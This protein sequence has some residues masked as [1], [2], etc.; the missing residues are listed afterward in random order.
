[1][2]HLSNYLVEILL[3][4][5]CLCALYYIRKIGADYKQ[6]LNTNKEG[7][8]DSLEYVR[9][10]LALQ[11]ASLENEMKMLSV[12]EAIRDNLHHL[13]SKNPEET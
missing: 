12:L 3:V 7:N 6:A 10:S 2:F 8:I 9:E 5:I 13:N 4:L 1:M 11:K